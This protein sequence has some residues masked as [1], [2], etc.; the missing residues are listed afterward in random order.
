VRPLQDLG[1]LAGLG[2]HLRS[3][4][5]VLPPGADRVV[6]MT[7]AY[8][9]DDAAALASVVLT[10]LVGAVARSG[11]TGWLTWLG[12]AQ[13]EHVSRGVVASGPLPPRLVDALLQAGSTPIDLPP[14]PGT[15]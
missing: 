4:T 5:F 15:P 12:G 10:D 3:V 14:P 13:V 2:R 9:D 11:K 1:R 8:V 6:R 7:L